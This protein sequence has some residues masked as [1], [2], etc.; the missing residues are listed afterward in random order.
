MNDKE[1][2]N[3]INTIQIEKLK[4]IDRIGIKTTPK[5]LA[6]LE[7]G[8]RLTS[9]WHFLYLN[10]EDFKLNNKTIR[11]NRNRYYGVSLSMGILWEIYLVLENILSTKDDIPDALFIEKIK[12]M[13]CLF[14]KPIYLR[15]LRIFRNQLSFH[16]DVCNICHGIIEEKDVKVDLIEM[17]FESDSAQNVNLNYKFAHV[18]SLEGFTKIN[19]RLLSQLINPY[20][21][22]AERNGDNIKLAFEKLF[23][24]LGETHKQITLKIHGLLTILQNELEISEI[25]DKDIDNQVPK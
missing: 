18:A 22:I 16:I 1:I 14:Q 5:F 23:E 10:E 19:W 9:L 2:K 7:G 20:N 24:Y 15:L 4:L 21:P 3:E 8:N 6:L 13:Q 12:E 11:N 25:K 17:E